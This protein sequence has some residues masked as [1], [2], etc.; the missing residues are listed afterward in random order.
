METISFRRNRRYT[1]AEKLAM[2][3]EVNS[4][5]LNFTE[6]SRKYGINPATIYRWRQNM[7][8]K[9]LEEQVNYSKLMKELETLKSENSHLKKAIGELTLDKQI[10][11]TAN[12]VLKKAQ[13]NQK[14]KSPKK[15]L[16]D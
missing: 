5:D 7:S 13:R 14:L 11:Q 16:K 10:L 2:L 4:G 6:L 3:K 12:E 1:K 8:T 15:S 9:Q